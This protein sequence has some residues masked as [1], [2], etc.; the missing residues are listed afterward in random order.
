MLSSAITCRWT[1]WRWQHRRGRQGVLELLELSICICHFFVHH[2]G[3]CNGSKAPKKPQ[4]DHPLTSALSVSRIR[5][6]TSLEITTMSL[7]NRPSY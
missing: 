4:A 2:H 7:L 6:H 5:D 3:A 1:R